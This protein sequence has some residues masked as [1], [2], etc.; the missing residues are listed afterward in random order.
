[1]DMS[2]LQGSLKKVKGTYK[3]RGYRLPVTG[4]EDDVN[5]NVWKFSVYS[6]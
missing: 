5:L 6:S 2:K 4:G 1:M 3:V